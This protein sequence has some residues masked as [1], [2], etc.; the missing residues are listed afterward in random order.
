MGKQGTAEKNSPI[1]YTEQLRRKRGIQSKWCKLNGF[2]REQYCS[3]IPYLAVLLGSAN[4]YCLKCLKLKSRGEFSIKKSAGDGLAT[5]CKSCM[6]SYYEEDKEHYSKTA[7]VRYIKN[8]N[9]ILSKAKSRYEANKQKILKKNVAYT[10]ERLKRDPIYKL[11]Y[12]HRWHI[13]RIM[14]DIFWCCTHTTKY[15]G[16]SPLKFK[17][18]IQ[19]L[20]EPNMT[21]ENYGVVWVLDHIIPLKFFD[22]NSEEERHMAMNYT[23]IRPLDKKENGKKRAKLPKVGQHE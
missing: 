2:T 15:L 9:R 23:N 5:Y 17:E 7:K 12:Q 1:K 18:Y 21:W 19:T 16:C 6:L 22:F 13:N 14:R 10:R 20:L 3:L 4:K 8:Q 11:K